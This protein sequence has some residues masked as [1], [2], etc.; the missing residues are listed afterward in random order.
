MTSHI[1]LAVFDLDGTLNQTHLYSVPAHKRVLAEFGV[2]NRTDA[3]II[4]CYGARGCDYVQDLMPGV[5]PVTAQAYHD[6]VAAYE[7]ETIGKLGR[8]FAGVPQMLDDLHAN[9]IRT[10]VCSNASLSYIDTVLT[11]LGLKE[12]IDDRQPLLDGLT[13][14]DTLKL[15]LTHISP[16]KAVMVGDRIFD[17]NAADFNGI[18]FIGCL[19][20]Y[21]P[22]EMRPCAHQVKQPSDLLPMLL[23]LL[24]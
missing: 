5:D 17:K 21:A 13:K 23:S 16:E 20:G 24:R 9:G 3:D 6:R 4:A 11:A 14:N 15:L 22:E 18:P 10:A 1:R 2:T 12:K 7:R 8:P 19:Y